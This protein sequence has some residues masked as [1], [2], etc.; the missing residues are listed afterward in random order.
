M[1]TFFSLTRHNK[2][3]ADVVNGKKMAVQSIEGSEQE[4]GME[5]EAEFRDNS[6]ISCTFFAD[7]ALL[8]FPSPEE[9][10]NK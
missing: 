1:E 10:S 4:N 2:S 6:F 9:I 7:H 8:I 3:R 5:T